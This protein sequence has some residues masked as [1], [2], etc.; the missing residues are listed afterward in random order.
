MTSKNG[1]FFV[2]SRVATIRTDINPTHTRFV[3]T[4]ESE[5]FEEKILF[6]ENTPYPID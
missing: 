4:P 1:F 5:E 6:L 2:T 3:K